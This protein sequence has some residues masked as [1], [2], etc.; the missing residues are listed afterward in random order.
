MH[1]GTNLPLFSGAS[2]GCATRIVVIVAAVLK[3]GVAYLVLVLA[4]NG[5][6]WA[7]QSDLVRQPHLMR[8][9]LVI[10]IDNYE[11][12]RDLANPVHDA[13]ALGRRLGELGYALYGG[14]VHLNVTGDEMH[15]LM[16]G[17]ANDLPQGAL[18]LV[19]LA[20]HG[21][22]QDGDTYLIPADD[23]ALARREDVPTH[24]V[25]LRALTARLA[26]REGVDA[27]VFV[28]ACRTNALRGDGPEVMFGAGGSGDLVASPTGSMALVYAAA[29]GQIAAD[30]PDGGEGGNPLSPFAQALLDVLAE[31]AR[32]FDVLMADLARRVHARTSAAQTPWVARTYGLDEPLFLVDR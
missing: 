5:P 18:A 15:A 27:V 17:F 20:G 7:E 21:L 16:R 28:D 29:P 31:P 30:G 14:Q 6:S 3:V 13:R 24:A 2:D 25:A 22:S 23:G 9:A 8:Q 26:G 10:G 1:L 32:P 12:A 11:Q 19:Y 4:L